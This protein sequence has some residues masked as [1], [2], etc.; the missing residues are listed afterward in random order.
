MATATQWAYDK[1]LDTKMRSST[2]R[3]FED[4]LREK[5]V[6]QDEAVQALVE[7]HQVFCAGLRSPGRPV[8]NLLFL[9]PTGSGKTRIVE[10]AAEILFGDSRAVVK[11]DCAEF[12]HSHEIAK[13]IGSPPGYLGHRETHPLITQEALAVSHRDNLKLS[14]LLFDEIEKAS[15]ALWQLLLGVL[16]KATLTLGDNRKVDLSQTVIF[17]TSNL[18]GGEITELMEGG[19]GFIQAK[20]KPAAG[21]D[22]RVERTAVEAARR[23]FSPEFM[24]RLDSVVVFR[25]LKREE[26]DEVLEIELGQVQK[27]VLDST[28]DSFLFRITS[29]GREFLLQEG[30]DQ[31]YGARHLKRAIERHLVSPLAR[32]LATAQVQSGDVL[33][34]D[35]HPGEKGLTFVKEHRSSYAQMPFVLWNSPQ[36]ASAD[37]RG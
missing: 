20:G 25:P 9:G 24:N 34:I 14:F 7:L 19:M 35:R 10:A 37:A 4:A 18:G 31:R 1:Q 26:L 21:L 28:T 11:V 6:G 29:E 8:G 13:L 36:L 23:K 30:T 32:L 22:A 12:Q 15:D 27:R 3:H 2:S 16:D 5:I 17:L 33:L